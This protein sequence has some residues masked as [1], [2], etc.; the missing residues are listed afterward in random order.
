MNEHVASSKTTSSDDLI[1]Y[2]VDFDNLEVIREF[3]LNFDAGN[4]LLISIEFILPLKTKT[5]FFVS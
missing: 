4:K 1:E 5:L 2:S 3:V